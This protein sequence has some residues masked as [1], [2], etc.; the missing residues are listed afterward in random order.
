M[1]KLL[2]TALVGAGAVTACLA[3]A[4]PASANSFDKGVVEGSVSYRDA[5]DNFCAFAHNNTYTRTYV[6]VKLTAL[7]RPG[8]SRDWKDL[9]TYYSNGTLNPTCR[10]LSSAHEDTK[11]RAEVWTYSAKRGTTVKRANFTFH[12]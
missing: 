1:K 3:L 5:S 6:R 7:S 11:Y 9:N 8:P 10:S 4:Q 12:S 2:R